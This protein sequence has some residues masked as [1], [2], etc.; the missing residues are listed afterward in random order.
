MWILKD[1]DKDKTLD[2]FLQRTQAKQP[3]TKKRTRKQLDKV[4]S[5][6]PEKIENDSKSQNSVKVNLFSAMFKKLWYQKN[7][8]KK[9]K[10]HAKSKPVSEDAKYLKFFTEPWL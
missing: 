1:S 10:Y 5:S 2:N 3:T 8:I 9:Q 4:L 7:P 6:S